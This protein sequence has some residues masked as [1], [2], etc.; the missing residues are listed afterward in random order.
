MNPE[1]HLSILY[2]ILWV[3]YQYG[4]TPWRA[5]I[6]KTS[7]ISRSGDALLEVSLAIL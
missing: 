6:L 3:D 2:Q 1:F 4:T 7:T 5:P